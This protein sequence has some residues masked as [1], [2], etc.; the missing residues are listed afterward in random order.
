MEKISTGVAGLDKILRGG[1]V[2][3]RSYLLTGPPGS[4]KCTLGVQFL[5]EGIKNQ[6][7]VLFLSLTKTEK[8]IKE[9]AKTYGWDVS[10]I[11]F[12]C[13]DLVDVMETPEFRNHRY[14]ENLVSLY[15]DKVKYSRLVFDSLKELTLLENQ[16][17][18]RKR[19]LRLINT[20]SNQENLTTLFLD[21]VANR[22]DSIEVYVLSGV[23]RF[24]FAR[25][26]GGRERAVGIEK[27]RGDFTDERIHPYSITNDGLEVLYDKVIFE[28]LSI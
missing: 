28:K 6:E 25:T 27:M 1:L 10:G 2:S 21:D 13:L 16:I 22:F 19:I 15:F 14:F 26:P 17:E 20:V 7:N 24:Y 23:I 11:E 18:A 4:G 5:H 9:L 8:E 12:L 3:D